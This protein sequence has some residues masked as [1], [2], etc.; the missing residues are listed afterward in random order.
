[1]DMSNT[2]CAC[3]GQLHVAGNCR[4]T[5]QYT[6]CTVKDIP[7]SSSGHTE[8]AHREQVAGSC[9]VMQTLC[10]HLMFSMSVAIE[11][12]ITSQGHQHSGN[13]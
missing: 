2:A 1:M 3:G 12:T 10:V 6:Y 8:H 11:H 13:V 9:W 4:E 5:M 7:V